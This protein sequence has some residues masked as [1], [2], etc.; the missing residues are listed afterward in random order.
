[1]GK[2]TE[3]DNDLVT[4]PLTPREITARRAAA[5]MSGRQRTTLDGR[6]IDE[7]APREAPREVKVD[8]RT[9]D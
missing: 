9:W 3:L 6:I 8:T 5:E 2:A 1:M 7:S 4:A